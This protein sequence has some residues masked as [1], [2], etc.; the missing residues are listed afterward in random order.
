LAGGIVGIEQGNGAD[1]AAARAQRIGKFPIGV[2]LAGIE[3]QHVDANHLGIV[4]R[5]AAHDLRQDVARKRKRA[6]L[7]DRVL[8]D[9]GDD[10][11]RRRDA[12]SHQGIAPVE[13]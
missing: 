13:R 6:R 2:R 3:Q 7:P 9:G 1:H 10:D 8:V 11:A 4:A 12:W 5:E